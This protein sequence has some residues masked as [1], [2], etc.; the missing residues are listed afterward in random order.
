MRPY[1]ECWA[2]DGLGW[3]P[4]SRK[5]PL[6]LPIPHHRRPEAQFHAAFCTVLPL[7]RWSGV[8]WMTR[9]DQMG[10]PGASPELVVLLVQA[11][12]CDAA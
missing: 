7:A 12:D 9:F 6:V 5:M 2:L 4:I 8:R 10:V 11:I 3:M 1:A